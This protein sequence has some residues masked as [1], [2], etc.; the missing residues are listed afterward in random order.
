MLGPDGQPLARK[1]FAEK[2]GKDLDVDEVVRGYEIDKE[3]YVI[4]TDEELERLAPE[5]TRDI[6]LKQF[7]PADSIPPLY[8]ERGYF[9]TPAEGSQKAYKLLAETMDKSDL[10]GV[11]TF[12]MRGKEYLVAIF[13]DKGI[14]RAETMRFADELRS[15][16]DIGLPKKKEAPKATVHKFEKL[17]A[18]KSKKQFTPTKLSDK[19]TDSLLKLVK[20]KQAKRA[21]VVK[22]EEEV[23][24]DHKVVDLVQILKK[25]LNA[26]R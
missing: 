2:T 18:T 7:V 11:A 20:K 5:K 16:A 13:S 4:V 15:P 17:I 25:S 22:V 3:K 26:K 12:V 19:Q 10:A 24:T 14:L 23:D 9:L 8:F 1:Y 21:N 6:D